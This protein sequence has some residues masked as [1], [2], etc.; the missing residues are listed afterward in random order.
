MQ[1]QRA[2]ATHV[3]ASGQRRQDEEEQRDD[4]QHHEEAQYGLHGDLRL[5]SAMASV[6]Q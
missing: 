4:G 3:C 6:E 2:L 1:L 5:E